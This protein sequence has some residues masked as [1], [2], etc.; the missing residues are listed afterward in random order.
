[1][2][3]GWAIKKADATVL[4]SSLITQFWHGHRIEDFKIDNTMWHSCLSWHVPLL[5]HSFKVNSGCIIRWV[6]LAS[7]YLKKLVLLMKFVSFILFILLFKL[8]QFAADKKFRNMF[9]ISTLCINKKLIIKKAHS[10]LSGVRCSP[11]VEK[12]RRLHSQNH[13]S[14]R[15][16]YLH[17]TAQPFLK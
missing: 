17:I 10:N 11:I 13:F 1:M 6:K 15:Y 14:N 16:Y 2:Y 5:K 12:W 3:T 9:F 7:I 8:H 4:R